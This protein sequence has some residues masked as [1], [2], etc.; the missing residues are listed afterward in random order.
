[1]LECEEEDYSILSCVGDME[2]LQSDEEGEVNDGDTEQRH[3]LGEV[4]GDKW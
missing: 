2:G 3:I 4:D 1:L